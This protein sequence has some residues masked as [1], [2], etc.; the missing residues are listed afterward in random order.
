MP[1]SLTL[2]PQLRP[3][4]QSSAIATPA[5][6]APNPNDDHV[7]RLLGGLKRKYAA[8]I[9]GELTMPAQPARFAEL[10]EALHPRLRA[11]LAARGLTRLYAHQRAAW[12]LA[13]RGEHLVVATPTASG[14][15]LCYNLPVLDAVLSRGA[16][17]LY[18]FPTKALAQDQ[19]AELA[20]LNQALVGGASAAAPSKSLSKLPPGSNTPHGAKARGAN[21]DPDPDQR[22]R[23]TLGI[24]AF[25]FDGD[26]PG[27]ARKAVRTRG[28]IVLSNPDMLHQAILPHHTKWAQFFESLEYVVVDELHS[29][30]GVFGSHVANVFRRLQRICRFYGASPR[31]IFASATIANPAALAGRLIGAEVRAV[32]DSGAPRGERHLL[33]W[34]PPV[35][36]P[37]L[38]IRASARSQTTRIAR[39]ATRQGLKNIVFARS[40]LMVEVITKYLKDVFDR[41]PRRPP[42]VLAY[43]GGYLPSERRSGE[44]ALRAGRVD[45]VVS[46]SALELGVDIGALDV[47]VLNGYPGTIAATWQRLGR[48]GRRNRPSLGVL[49]ATSD[50]LD[51]Y[52][53]R[54]PEFFLG[55]SP[56]HA[57]IHPDQLLILM[58]HVRC[59]A[60]ELPFRDGEAFGDCAEDLAEMLA[61]LRDEGLLQRQGGQWYWI[62]DSYPANAVSLR[63]VAEGNF[64]VI[65]TSGGKQ[66]IIAEVDYTGAPGTVYEGAIYMVQSQ[67]YQ[68]ER[69]DWTG[70]KAFVTKTRADY[71]TDAIDYTKL[72][73]LA[74]FDRI[75]NADGA[76]GQAA[77]AHGEVHLVRRYPGYKKIR[78]YSHDNIGYGNIDL[79]DQEMHTTAVW[80]QVHPRALEAAIAETF[81]GRERAVEG[82]LGA[83]YALHH[84]AALRAMAELGDLGRAV[85]DGQ[86]RWFAVVGAD[87]RGQLR[88]PDNEQLDGACL[89]GRFEPTLF[90]YD[91][92][93]G[94]VGLSA[95][96]FDAA[97]AL[98]ADAR[99]LV[100]GCACRAGCPA[101]IGPILPG[102]EQR[103]QTPKHLALAVLGLLEGRAPG[104]EDRGEALPGPGTGTLSR[105]SQQT[106]DE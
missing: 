11:A 101:C 5:Q 76:A 28:D 62:A 48:A 70:R 87:G 53:V 54:H 26:T 84:V 81:G 8:R 71:Y 42:R 29:Y 56:E 83:A 50:P 59:A 68:V 106:A 90:L 105:P 3:T 80:W 36:D 44:Q 22:D 100:Q 20:E 63:S 21:I 30:R 31:F 38:G 14:K 4:E 6:R 82:F 43:R 64:V 47:A 98:L 45:C 99:A 75:T 37:D 102:D 96:L 2:P 18:L 95:P 10:P 65:D 91:N 92:Y 33:L 34:N 86:G 51:Q 17:A 78:Y 72:K 73:I 103:V 89:A 104:A 60:F 79:P 39:A 25:T 52:M 69:L 67:P 94:G 40:R 24:K 41:D 27:D 1:A 58:D 15:T 57:R 97:R 55:R 9:T 13:Q 85:G 74:E 66:T 61:Y 77:A 19:V 49:V 16:K 46:T 35:I 93:P 23:G 32:T 7:R 88:G 12:D